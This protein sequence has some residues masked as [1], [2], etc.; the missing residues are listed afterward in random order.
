MSCP[1]KSNFNAGVREKRG[2]RR[3]NKPPCPEKDNAGVEARK[4]QDMPMATP[5]F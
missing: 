4:K 2:M 1:E 3:E 5:G